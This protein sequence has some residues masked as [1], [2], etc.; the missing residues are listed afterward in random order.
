[1]NFEEAS[2]NDKWKI[3][4]NEE[5][6]VIKKNDN[7]ELSTLPNGKKAVGH[8]KWVFKIK[9]NEKGE[10]ERYK[11]RF[12]AKGYSQRKGIVT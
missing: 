3:A 12:V 11:A 6:E 7:W 5:I 8:V 9:R 10:L 1:M 4:M 2:Q